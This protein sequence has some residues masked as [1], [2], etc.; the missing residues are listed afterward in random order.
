MTICTLTGCILIS[1]PVFSPG[2]FIRSKPKRASISSVNWLR[3]SRLRADIEDPSSLVQTQ[4]HNYNKL[5]SSSW[6]H[7]TSLKPSCTGDW[8]CL[9][10][11]VAHWFSWSPLCPR[12]ALY[13]PLFC[14]TIFWR[15]LPATTKEIKL[16]AGQWSR[17]WKVSKGNSKG[18]LLVFLCH[19]HWH[20]WCFL[21]LARSCSCRERSSERRKNKDRLSNDELLNPKALP[22]FIMCEDHGKHLSCHIGKVR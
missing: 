12:S 4:V 7:L 3:S 8:R 10:E 9:N 21:I 16:K 14:R 5:I 6:H 13:L 17:M 11:R 22:C 2:S 1:Q 18:C 20:R 15:G 19:R